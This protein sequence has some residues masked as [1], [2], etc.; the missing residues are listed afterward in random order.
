MASPHV[1]GAAALLRQLHPKL[2]QS[3]IKA[4]LQNSTVNA[5]AS[6]DTKLTRQGV[7]VVRVDKAAALTSY[8]SP[9]GVSFGRLNP[10]APINEV[11][12]IT[13]T[14]LTSA[15]HAFT[16]KLVENRSMPGVKVICPSSVWVGGQN[17]IE[18]H[19]TL[20]F[21]PRVSGAA[22]VYDSGLASQTEVDGWCVFN[23][24]KEQLRVGYIAVVDPASNISV[25]SYPAKKKAVV[26]NAGPAVGWA[27][28]FT[29][30]LPDG[31]ALDPSS[32]A[33]AAG[34]RRADESIYGAKVLEIGVSAKRPFTHI[35]NLMF[36]FLVDTNNDGN[37]DVEVL[38]IDYSYLNSNADPGT[39]V[40]AQ[41]DLATGDGFIDW[42]VLTW[43][44]NDNAAIFPFTLA[45]DGNL[46]SFLP[47]KFSFELH[48]INLSDG[49][50]LDVQSGLVDLSKE[51]VPDLNSFGVGVKEKIEVNM[52]GS[53][54]SLWLFQNNPV[55]QQKD[56]SRVQ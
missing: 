55:Q 1:A 49:N 13:F 20:K 26:R 50:E 30:A 52:K 33:S 31:G 22:N 53:G 9:G 35:S 46:L 48:T 23:D 7:G 29:L 40:T 5:N 17:S 16:S 12:E 45:S 38:A 43:D 14:S 37:A 36:D 19:I 54:H 18:T 28:A 34:F 42:Q 24:G 2:N 4:L 6:Y 41:F 11:R 8:A 10:I 47:D 51:I 3:G 15:P 44:F 27:E 56:F 21:D 39:Y 32:D 25:T